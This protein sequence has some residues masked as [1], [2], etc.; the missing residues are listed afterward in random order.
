[1]IGHLKNNHQIY[2][3]LL[4]IVYKDQDILPWIPQPLAQ[5]PEKPPQDPRKSPQD[6]RNQQNQAD[7]RE[8][9]YPMEREIPSEF[10]RSLRSPGAELGAGGIELGASGT[11][12]QEQRQI[13]ET[14]GILQDEQSVWWKRTPLN[15]GGYNVTPVNIQAELQSLSKPSLSEYSKQISESMFKELRARQHS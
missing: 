11:I 13:L 8:K 7:L 2:Q 4:G 5:L 9:G 12:T 14:R 15:D 10:P 6:P 1:M 3:Q